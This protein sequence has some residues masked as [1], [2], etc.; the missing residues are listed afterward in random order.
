MSD[1]QANHFLVGLGGTGGKVLR[2]F[3]KT[4][5]QNYR[6]DSPDG[7]NLGYLYVD[8][9]ESMMAL[10]DPTWKILGT[11][12]QLQPSSQLKIAGLN[13]GDVLKVDNS[14]NTI[15]VS[16]KRISIVNKIEKKINNIK[17]NTYN[18]LNTGLYQ[19]LLRDY[20]ESLDYCI[21]FNSINNCRF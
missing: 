2:S 8:S 17:L 14:L 4:I 13:L 9:N 6:K 19:N 11:N 3:R 5:Y 16:E 18:M 12:V 15:L 7:I 10:D 1:L 21:S 20:N